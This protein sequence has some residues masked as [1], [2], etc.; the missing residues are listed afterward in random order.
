MTGKRPPSGDY[1]GT[2]MVGAF[3]AF[4]IILGVATLAYRVNADATSIYW[5][6][7]SPQQQQSE[8]SKHLIDGGVAWEPFPTMSNES[9]GTHTVLWSGEV[10]P[11]HPCCVFGVRTAFAQAEPELSARALRATLDANL[12]IAQSLSE[13]DGQNYST[14]C[15]MAAASSGATVPAIAESFRHI[16]YATNITQQVKTDLA[17]FADMFIDLNQISTSTLKARGFND[18]AEL[19]DSMV[20]QKL[21]ADALKVEPSDIAIGTVNFGYIQADIH[22]LA[23]MVAHSSDIFGAKSLFDRYGVKVVIPN[24]VGF[25]NG[26]AVMDAFAT[27]LLDMAYLGCAPAILK[28]VNSNV[29]VSF[30]SLA[31][32]EGSA[33]YAINNINSFGDLR[34]KCIATPGPSSI[35]HLLLQYEANREGIVLKLRGT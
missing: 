26:G 27:E 28:R 8:I 16:T 15:Q 7:V 25:S 13:P 33:I 14:L 2:R 29:Q 32:K 17:S 4:L 24:P 23:F 19:I 5:V 3:L 20:D 6:T 11:E 34:G 21:F 1:S 31:N 9:G 22:D 18:T 12:W 30:A 35:Q 10:W